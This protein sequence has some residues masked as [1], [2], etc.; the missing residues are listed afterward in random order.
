MHEDGG[1][2]IH[3]GWED[4]QRSE[5]FTASSLNPSPETASYP[6]IPQRAFLDCHKG[7][8]KEVKAPVVVLED[9]LPSLRHIGATKR[10]L[11]FEPKIF[12]K[13]G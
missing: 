4:E 2:L 5:S 8:A 12:I 11:Q 6:Q 13:H 3:N 1:P 10:R 9:L 7:A